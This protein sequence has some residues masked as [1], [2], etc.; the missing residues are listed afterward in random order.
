LGLLGGYIF[1]LVG[2]GIYVA[3]HLGW[4]WTPDFG[5]GIDFFLVRWHFML[6]STFP[7]LGLA[8]G[9]LVC[10]NRLKIGWREW[11]WRY[12]STTPLHTIT[13]ILLLVIAAEITVAISELWLRGSTADA[14]YIDTIT[15]AV[16]L[17]AVMY[18]S[19]FIFIGPLLE[20]FVFRGALYSALRAVMPVS[21]ALFIQAAA[22]GLAHG[23]MQHAAPIFLLGLVLGYAYQRTGSLAIPVLIHGMMNLFAI[24]GHPVYWFTA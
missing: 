21:A 10:R 13:L 8:V 7:P 11:G 3:H 1:G 23:S 6:M 24:S 5:A 20:E 22:F 4:D 15:E 19:Y 18:I 14:L 12:P 17:H 16:G 9:V 2:V